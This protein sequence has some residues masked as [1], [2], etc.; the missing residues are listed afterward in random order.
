MNT[1]EVTLELSGSVIVE[2][3][4]WDEGEAKDAARSEWSAGD[5]DLEVEWVTSVECT[6]RDKL[7]VDDLE[8]DERAVTLE[9]ITTTDR[10]FRALVGCGIKRTLYAVPDGV[11]AAVVDNGL[12]AC[13]ADVAQFKRVGARVY[14]EATSS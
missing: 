1:Y 14:L 6:Q 12:A 3:D 10:Q 2:V 13:L 7:T 9:V 4:A 11:E 5:A 8:D